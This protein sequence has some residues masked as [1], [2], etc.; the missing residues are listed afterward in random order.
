MY[1]VHV[2]CSGVHTVKVPEVCTGH[3]VLLVDSVAHV[4]VVVGVL[5]ADIE[6]LHK[7]L[8]MTWTILWTL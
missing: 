3:L 8:G 1:A 6:A 4:Q 5:Q 7:L 2:F